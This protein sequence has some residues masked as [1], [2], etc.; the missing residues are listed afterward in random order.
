MYEHI[1]RNE[2]KTVTVE[3][4]EDMILCQRDGTGVTAPALRVSPVALEEIQRKL[5]EE[6]DGRE[7][8]AGELQA[9][10]HELVDTGVNIHEPVRSSILMGTVRRAGDLLEVVYDTPTGKIVATVRPEDIKHI[11]Y[12]E[13]GI[14]KPVSST[15]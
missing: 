14:V 12:V 7:P 1:T 11:S 4:R 3:L 13:E 5:S 6:L 9:R 15:P 10:I 2:G 8:S